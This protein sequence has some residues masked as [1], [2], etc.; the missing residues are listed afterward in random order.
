MESICKEIEV[1][2]DIEEIKEIKAGKEEK[3]RMVIVKVKSDE[4]RRKILENKRKLRGKEVWIEKDQTFKE[5][6]MKWKLRQ[7]AGEEERREE[8]V[9]IGYGKLWTGDEARLWDKKEEE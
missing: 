8:R 6:K 7:I 2:I 1:S 4:S 9:R 3:G 5:R